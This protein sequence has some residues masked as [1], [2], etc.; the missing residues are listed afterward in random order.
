MTSQEKKTKLRNAFRSFHIDGTTY[1]IVRPGRGQLL[2]SYFKELT[3]IN[4]FDTEHR[5]GMFIELMDPNDF[6]DGWNVQEVACEEIIKLAIKGTI[7]QGIRV[8]SKL[9]PIEGDIISLI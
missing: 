4:V 9:A 2:V 6:G 7:Y 1:T 5:A 8:F 3:L